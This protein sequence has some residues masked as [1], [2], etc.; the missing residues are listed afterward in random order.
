MRIAVSNRGTVIET[1]ETEREAVRAF[2]IFTAHELK[3]GRDAT[4]LRI[5]E[6]T[7]AVCAPDP[8]D[9]R[10]PDWA[11]EVLVLHGWMGAS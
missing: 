5:G 3:N 8:A 10:L 1:C 11:I 4:G 6:H 7:D 9:C 2:W